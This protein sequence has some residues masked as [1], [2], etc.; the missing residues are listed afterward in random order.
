MNRD[1]TF[2]QYYPKNSFVHNIDP[3]VKI[4]LVI[5]YMAGVF[6][7]KTL[8]AYIP[9]AVFLALAV[10]FSRVPPLKV[11]AS[12]K[13]ILILVL[14][15]S[16]MNVFFNTHG[17]PLITLG[18]I[19]ITEGGVL[20]AMQ[21]SLRLVF[22]VCGTAV[23]TLTTTPTGIT[24]GLESLLSPLKIVRFPVQDIAMIMS[25][26]LRFIPILSEET[27]KIILAQKARGANFERGGIIKRARALIPVL[28]P[29]LVS[30]FRRAEE[31]ALAMDARCYNATP[32]RTRL[33]ELKLS[34][35]DL[36]AVILV[37]GLIVSVVFL[38]GY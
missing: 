4:V 20:I 26:A 9:V 38:N 8:W 14:F 23:L 33:K 27:Q 15:T 17:E 31:L 24:T 29:L 22:L 35:R 12:I 18:R 19:K 25:I 13:G 5:A 3:R 28:I 11:L 37:A 2:G 21:L 16:I 10:A 36:V 1:V 34:F 6:V 32:K 30:A 7:A